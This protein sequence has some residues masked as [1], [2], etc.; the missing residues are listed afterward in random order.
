[1]VTKETKWIMEELHK[2]RNDGI[3]TTGITVCF[4]L[5]TVTFVYYTLYRTLENK[6]DLYFNWMIIYLILA[7]LA[8]IITFFWMK[9][10][11]K[12]FSDNMKKFEQ[13]DKDFREDMEKLDK[14]KMKKPNKKTKKK[15]EG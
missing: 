13:L 14:A 12:K 5:L 4:Y 1:M 8:L 6:Q 7:T 3:W 9:N 10:M 2:I 15:T 11:K